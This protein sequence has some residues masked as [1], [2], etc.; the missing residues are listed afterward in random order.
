MSD[1]NQAAQRV[2][3]NIE[4][5]L[6]TSYLD[7]AM[8]VIIGRALPDVRDGLKPVHRRVLF[9]MYQ[10]GNTSEK[11]YRKSAKTV[12][13]VIG[14]YH[15]HGDAAVYDTIVRMAQDF[16]LR[17]P[18]V[19]GQG[20][21]GSVDG[22]PPAA[23]R[24]T[25][26]RMA[27]L[28]EMLLADIDK[29]TADFGPNYDNTEEE[30]LV[31]PCA[32]PHLLANGAE[33]IAVGMATRIPP[34][35]LRELVDAAEYLIGNPDCT[36]S[37]LMEFVTGPDFPTAG[38]IYGRSGIR[39]AYA[40]GRGRI[41][42]R[43]RIDFEEGTKGSRDKL[44]ITQLPYQVNKAQLIEEIAALVHEKKI[45]GIADL[46][47]ESDR[48]GIRAVIELRKDAV[49][50]VVMSNLFKHTRL[51]TTFGAI[52][53][54]IV[55]GRPR[56]LDLKSMLVHYVRH[57]REVVV[58]RTQ[59]LLRQAE[60]RAHILEGL[61]KALDH[62]DAIIALIRSSAT[63]GEAKTRLIDTFEFTEIQAQ[64]IL[65]MRLQRL[66]QLEREKLLEELAELL[67]Q[68]E[69][70][71]QILGSTQ[72]VDQ[73]VVEEL[74]D[75][76]ARFGDERRTQIVNE[77]VEIT[78][79]DTISDEQVVITLS[80]RDYVKRTSL[81]EYR[82]QGRGGK[83]IR[84]MEVGEDDFV[85]RVRI[86]RTH[87]YSFWFTS[88]GRV[89]PLPVH[90][91][92]EFGR[93]ARGR[94]IVNL[95]GLK[96]D[97]KV[98]G[99]LVVR[100]LD[101]PDRY[102]V[103]ITRQGIVKRTELGAYSNIRSGGLIALTLDEGDSLIAV[104][105]IGHEDHLFMATRQGMAIRF[106]AEEVRPM[107]RTARGVRGIELREGDEVVNAIVPR[108]GEDI[109]TATVQGYGK[110]TALEEY[111]PQGRGGL[112]LINL[113]VSDKTG[114]VVSSVPVLP[115][116]ELIVATRLGQVIRTP[117]EQDENNRI[118]RLGRS[119][120]G[121][122]IIRLNEEDEVVSVTRSTP[123]QGAEPTPNGEETD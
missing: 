100:D 41:L 97:E 40:T 94:A 8:S 118:S 90:Q 54:A 6:R 96:A 103:T 13:E 85:R 27:R 67:G 98:Q 16:S 42:V 12:G 22:D 91:L 55:S 77:E 25:E 17:Y 31:L 56:V 45:E 104:H 11:T 62:L 72:L 65:D 75:I 48:E 78:D 36:V 20:N 38:I 92:P 37:D 18:L 108:E 32:L 68:I 64:A 43:G 82:S 81:T 47:D 1:E 15:P 59:F 105:L 14:K 119:T 3:V 93:A 5:E 21:F 60:A 50:K 51:Q 66:T 2:P 26:I 110:R 80:N 107:G 73:V 101:Q 117:V 106:P 23:M 123:V 58:R 115:E 30:P 79:L 111:R 19:D 89:Y 114:P 34:H 113:K 102:V 122:R 57:R 44:V 83:G 28:G 76:R 46:R 69:R 9:A 63:P 53:L 74:R 29:E 95:L 112:G 35:N 33:G 4:D 61:K 84:L 120:Q 87:D 121:V 86:A 10:A 49:P 116:D 7:Y 109:L 39:Q 24:Y 71:R 99:L 70:Y 88:R 52:F